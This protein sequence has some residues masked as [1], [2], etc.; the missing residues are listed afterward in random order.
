VVEQQVGEVGLHP[1]HLGTLDSSLGRF[2]I[3][4]RMRA[5]WTGSD[6]PNYRNGF[7]N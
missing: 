7:G 5:R 6:P 2:Q 3:I 4:Y 1:A